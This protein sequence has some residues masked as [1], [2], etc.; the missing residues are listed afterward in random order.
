[1]QSMPDFR[2]SRNQRH[3]FLRKWIFMRW[4]LIAFFTDGVVIVNLVGIDPKTLRCDPP[5]PNYATH[6]MT[7][8]PVE[9]TLICVRS[10]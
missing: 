3:D 4:F 5:S 6:I 8:L 2:L 1:M 9:M 10:N 7:S